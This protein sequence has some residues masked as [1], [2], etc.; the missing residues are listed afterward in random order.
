MSMIAED[1]V[2]GLLF[3]PSLSLPQSG[4][5]SVPVM[6]EVREKYEADRN[7]KSGADYDGYCVTHLLGNIG[8]LF[9]DEKMNSL[10]PNK[11]LSHG[12]D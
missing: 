9:S 7:S 11:R 10:S 5:N 8:F 1:S 6:R 2:T 12:I 4:P 3:Q